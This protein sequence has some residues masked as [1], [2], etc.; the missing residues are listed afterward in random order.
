MSNP[1]T[2]KGGAPNS[3]QTIF[4]AGFLRNALVYFSQFNS[5]G[6]PVIVVSSAPSFIRLT[7]IC[8]AQGWVEIT[9]LSE[10]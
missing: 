8:G 7:F 6:R 2:V 5:T 1:V 3:G 9:L 10:Y 4:Y